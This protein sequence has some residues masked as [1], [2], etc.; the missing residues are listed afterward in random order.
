[1]LSSLA[2]WQETR[3]LAGRMDGSLAIIDAGEAGGPAADAVAPRE[4]VAAAEPLTGEPIAH[5]EAEPN[6]TPAD[7]ETV[8]L[9]ASI[10]GSMNREGDSDCFR[11][12]AAA[13][14]V[15]LLDV[16]AAR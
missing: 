16:E 13:G 2:A 10:T 8:G 14:Q 5:A 4:A 7:A 11:F 1:M 9:P 12:T 15:L 6:D 3:F